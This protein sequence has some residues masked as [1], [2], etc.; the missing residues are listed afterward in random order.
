[1]W[2][3]IALVCQ[4]P[5][6]FPTFCSCSNGLYC[7][8]C[9]SIIGFVHSKINGAY[10]QCAKRQVFQ[11]IGNKCGFRS[12]PSWDCFFFGKK[13]WEVPRERHFLWI[14]FLDVDWFLF[15]QNINDK[16]HMLV[17]IYGRTEQPQ[18]HTKMTAW[19]SMAPPPPKFLVKK[20]VQTDFLFLFL[21]RKRL[22][23]NVDNWASQHLIRPKT[24]LSVRKVAYLRTNDLLVKDVV[25]HGARVKEMDGICPGANANHRTSV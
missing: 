13:W 8:M 11:L 22:K 12:A 2:L 10:L 21:L 18:C 5:G 6:V 16:R 1:M 19:R 23:F 20:S 4:F 17:F 9:I 24:H 14:G 15:W 3:P 25:V 7:N